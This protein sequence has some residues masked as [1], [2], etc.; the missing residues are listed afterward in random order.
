M[1]RLYRVEKWARGLEW[2]TAISL[3]AIPVAIIAGLLRS[4]I[5]PEALDAAL[6]NHVVSPSTTQ[7]QLYLAIGIM[8]IP[9][10]IVMFTLNAMRKL[11]RLY[12]QGHI[13]TESCALFIQRIGQG[14]LALALVRLLMRPLLSGVLS[15]ARPPD[16]RS[17]AFILNGEMYFFA[18]SGGLILMIG[19]AMREASR[20]AAENRAFV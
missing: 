3:I 19:W 18:V 5:T 7:L 8:L 11:F 13:L 12:R 9:P 20:V 10:V 14:F 15:L 1:N 2:V 16:E 4:P 17:I 6:E